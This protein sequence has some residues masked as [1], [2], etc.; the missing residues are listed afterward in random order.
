LT[1]NTPAL[2]DA[3]REGHRFA[4]ILLG[5]MLVAGVAAF[6]LAYAG[7]ALRPGHRGHL[8]AGAALCA[9]AAGALVA[10]FASYGSPWTIAQKGYD[11]FRAPPVGSSQPGAD[12]NRRLISFSG[13]GR[14]DMWEAAWRSAREDP[15]LGAGAGTYEQ[16]WLRERP[17][18]MKVRDAHSLYVETLAGL[19]PFGLGLLTAALGLPLLAAVRARRRSLTSAAFGAYV[20]YLAHTGVDWDWEM[21]A[22]TLTGLFCGAALLVAA[23]DEQR[24]TRA[25]GGARAIVLAG[26]V[27]VLGFSL[28]GLVSN[29][30]LSASAE[31]ASAENWGK[32]E[33]EARK[34][35]R[36]APW[37]SAGW[38][39]LGQVQLEQGKLA[40]A[41]SS[42]RRAIAKDARDWSLWLNLALASE[43]RARQEAAKVALELNPLS[44]EIALLRPAL[45]LP[46]EG[47]GS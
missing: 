42:F 44:P 34:A 19:G 9:V 12:L 14:A 33:A 45:R 11:E 1:T 22:V 46:D 23:R 6:A 24:A 15:W 35:S 2:E 8:A 13:N 29:S 28:V 25:S 40:A 7:R 41:Q 39:Q 30:A 43:G 16:F 47:G 3:T 32:A 5:L 17:L 18:P 31:A 20:A 10:V 37:S 4:L 26:V 36:W 38:R 27:A 21:T